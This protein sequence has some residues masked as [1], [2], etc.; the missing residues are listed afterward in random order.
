MSAGVPA[1]VVLDNA[2]REQAAQN[3]L[4]ANPLVGVRLEDILDSARLLLG[5]MLSSPG[6]AALE[7]LRFL[8][9]L[10]RIA[11]GA[12]ELAPDAKDKRFAD[13]AWKDS[14][15]YRALVQSY[16][17][18]AVH[19]TASWMRPK[20]I[21]AMPNARASSSLSWSTQWRRPIQFWATRLL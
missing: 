11:T 17:A 1:A 7:Y 18:W 12:S 19:S 10:G 4:A 15:I 2:I 14:A 8:S 13:P 20:W 6:V 21:S 16:L 9:E 3:T 5:Q